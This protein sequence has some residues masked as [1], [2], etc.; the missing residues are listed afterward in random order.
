MDIDELLALELHTR[1]LA[2]E[3]E[4]EIEEAEKHSAP[5]G[6]LDGTEG[7]ISRQ[8]SM[9]HHEIAKD[10]QRRRRHRLRLLQEAIQRI[11]Q[12]TFGF[13]LTCGKEIDPARLAAT[14]ETPICGPCSAGQG[15]GR[16]PL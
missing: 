9:I 6:Q 12:G 15:A 16:R 2:I 10:A 8:D 7:R 13:C 3:L 1:D 11:D 5:P 4:K 14:P